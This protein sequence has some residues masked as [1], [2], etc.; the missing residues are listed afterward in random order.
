VIIFIVV[1]ILVLAILALLLRY[2]ISANSR[3]IIPLGM[4]ID[5]ETDPG[6]ISAL[7]ALN[8]GKPV[9]L[10]QL[11]NGNWIMYTG[12]IKVEASSPNTAYTLLLEKIKEEEDEE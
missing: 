10:S 5:V 6:M 3:E 8:I 7:A 11:D 9:F 1:T 4:E 12:K 2:Y